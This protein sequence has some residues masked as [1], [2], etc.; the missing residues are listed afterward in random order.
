ML[1][2]VSSFALLGLDVVDVTVEVNVADRGFPSFDIVGLPNK[3]IAESREGIK[4]ALINSGIPFPEKRI[5][6]NLA[7]ADIQKEGTI[8]DF[9]IAVGI[10]CAIYNK[11][12]PE[13]SLFFGELSLDG[14]IKINKGVFIASLYCKEKGVSNLFCPENSIYEISL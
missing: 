11:P 1:V 7:P 13:N 12:V 8:Y 2:K 3:A 4:T 5:T 10:I 14:T 6:V 9:P